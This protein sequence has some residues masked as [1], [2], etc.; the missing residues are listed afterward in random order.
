M[1]KHSA[2]IALF[3]FFATAGCAGNRHLTKGGIYESNEA[4]CFVGDFEPEWVPIPEVKDAEMAYWNQRLGAVIAVNVTCDDYDDMPTR[5]MANHLVMGLEN[6]K[7]DRWEYRPVDGRQA[8]YGE[9]EGLLDGVPVKMAAYVIVN[10]YCSF[11]LIYHSP[12][13]TFEEGSRRLEKL[14]SVFKVI[15]AGRRQ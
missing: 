6:R 9:V 15:R 5:A 1:L 4:Q 14:A 8:L 13:N 3:V 10:N 2:I 12:P 11:D 7:Y